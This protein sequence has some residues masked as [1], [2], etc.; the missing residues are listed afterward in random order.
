MADT[1]QKTYAVREDLGRAIEM[2][3]A[4]D[5]KR[6]SDVVNDAFLHYVNHTLTPEERKVYGVTSNEPKKK[7]KRK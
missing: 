3:A 1:K 4:R 7:E 6:I 5:D 2:I